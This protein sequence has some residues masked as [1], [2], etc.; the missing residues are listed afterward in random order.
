MRESQIVIGNYTYPRFSF[1]YYLRSMNRLGVTT[2][3]L[4][5]GDPHLYY[6]DFSIAETKALYKT[7]RAHGIRVCCVT[8]EQCMYP[9]NIGSGNPNARRRSVDFFKRTVQTAV[10]MEAPKAFITSGHHLWDERR[11]DCYKW[12]VESLGELAEY[13]RHNGVLFC[14][15]PLPKQIDIAT[16]AQSMM[17]LLGEVNRF[18]A[19]RPM[20]DVSN[21]GIHGEACADY[22]ETC[23]GLIS[24]VHFQDSGWSVPGDGDLPLTE[25]LECLDGAGYTGH[26][27]VEIQNKRYLDDPEQ[28]MR[29]SLQFLRGYMAD[30][31]GTTNEA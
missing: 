21:M 28:A 29:R 23:G 2:M 15:E 16:T 18:D 11:E 8:P 19:L 5:A 13:A 1:D 30:G 9:I 17:R 26:I 24:H 7:I 10:V 14:F 27:S 20:L 6:D 22:L 12:C 31:G 25:I 4:W 3:E